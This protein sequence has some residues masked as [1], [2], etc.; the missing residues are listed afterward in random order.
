MQGYCLTY[1]VIVKKSFL[2]TKQ[3]RFPTGLKAKETGFLY[4]LIY[5]FSRNSHAGGP[6]A[7]SRRC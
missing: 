4:A 7:T 3:N 1:I 6:C 2:R 5:F